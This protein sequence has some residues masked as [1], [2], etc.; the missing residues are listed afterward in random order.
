MVPKSNDEIYVSISM[1]KYISTFQLF[2]VLCQR[3][4]YCWKYQQW[5]SQLKN[6]YHYAKVV[7]NAMI[8][9][10]ISP[11]CTLLLSR[12][13]NFKFVQVPLPAILCNGAVGCICEDMSIKIMPIKLWIF[14][15]F[16]KNGHKSTQIRSKVCSNL[17]CVLQQLTFVLLVSFLLTL[18]NFHTLL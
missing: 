14:T 6:C 15:F 3:M 9:F 16:S 4:Y 2:S 11:Y 17:T 8:N 18:N 5:G 7:E 10:S 1:G 12:K 13:E